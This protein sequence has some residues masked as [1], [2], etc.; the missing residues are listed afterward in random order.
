MCLCAYACVCIYIYMTRVSL[1]VSEGVCVCDVV[2]FMCKPGPDVLDPLC[3]FQG[4]AL[5]RLLFCINGKRPARGVTQPNLLHALCRHWR[6]VCQNCCHADVCVCVCKYIVR[7][8]RM[9]PRVLSPVWR[10]AAR[11]FSPPGR[12]RARAN[13]PGV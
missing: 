2:R 3:L 5:L 4:T 1:Q 13:A 12:R 7:A 10:P 6:E 9:A 8:P 11:A